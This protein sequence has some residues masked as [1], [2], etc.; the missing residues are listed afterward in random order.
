MSEK[1][2]K[3]DRASRKELLLAKQRQR[4]K[5]NLMNLLI[6]GLSTVLVI[7]GLVVAYHFTSPST[8]QTSSPSPS[9][10]ASPSASSEQNPIPT[11]EQKGSNKGAVPDKS[12]A[13]NKDWDAVIHTS[14]GDL[15][16]TLFGTKAPQAVANFIDLSRKNWWGTNNAQCPRITTKGVWI[17]Q[18]GAPNGDQSG[19]PGYSFGPVENAPKDNIYKKGYIAMARSDSAYSNGSQ[20]FI[21]YQDSTF[22]PGG[23][24]AGY[25]VFGEIKKGLDSIEGFAKTQSPANDDGKPSVEVKITGVDIK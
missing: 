11:S 25:A 22:P 7:T 20:F 16:I 24:Q 17:L 13:E 21:M 4:N 3:F 1:S 23:D 2:R 8:Y 12:I 6:I 18:C 14:L 19:G 5:K 9:E 10:S 15:D